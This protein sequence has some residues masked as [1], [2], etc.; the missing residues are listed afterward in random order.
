MAFPRGVERANVFSHGRD[1]EA[2]YD[3]VIIGGGTSGLPVADRLTEDGK[4]TVL[5]LEYG[6]L[7]TFVS[8]SESKLRA[9]VEGSEPKR[10]MKQTEY[11]GPLSSVAHSAVWPT[12]Q[13]GPL[14]S[15]AVAGSF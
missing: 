7:S 11:S 10:N 3:Y 12:R 8:Y 6:K 5:V 15:V 13:S 1:V 2:A 4:T 14:S 9:Q